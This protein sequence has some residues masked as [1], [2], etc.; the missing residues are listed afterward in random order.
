MRM[1]NKV[2]TCCLIGITVLLS[3]CTSNEGCTEEPLFPLG[4]YMSVAS[5]K[6]ELSS[7]FPHYRLIPLETNDASLIGGRGN[8]IIKRDSC[9]YIQSENTI[10]C[11]NQEGRFL[12]R[13]AH[14]G[15]GPGEYAEIADFDVVPSSGGELEVWISGASGWQIYDAQSGDF[16]RRIQTD[17]YIHQFHYVNDRTLLVITS[18]DCI[19][20]ICDLDGNIR[21]SF[22]EKDLA[23][24]AHK[25]NQF[26]TY[27]GKVAY[28]L[29]DTQTAIVYDPEADDCFL[30]P[31]LQPLENVLT[32]SISQDY[33]DRYGYLEQY[34]RLEES[35]TLL[36]T[37]R[38]VGSK[39][40]FTWMAP[41]RDYLLM[42]LSSTGYQ[43]F[44]FSSIKN[45]I[46]HT[47][48]NRFLATLICCEGDADSVLLFQ[49]PAEFIQEEG[50][51]EEDN[52]WLLEVGLE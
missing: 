24:S 9:F 23:N 22:Y 16:V 28:Q 15:N 4:D 42:L 35:Y 2:I 21:K 5:E 3:A 45:D 12:H 41:N 10:L 34:D 46:I 32:P 31:I 29:G 33:Y 49:I 18:D 37:V 40:A 39:G 52:F 38:A 44:H 51:N 14:Q 26:F 27:Q 8:K 47:K 19:F 50:V 7:I 25:F 20:H 13:I 43:T 1:M 36:S 17:S 30:Q 11:F 6:V 48:D